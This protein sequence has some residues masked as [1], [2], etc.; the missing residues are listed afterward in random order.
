MKHEIAARYRT[1]LATAWVAKRVL[2]TDYDE[3]D[4]DEAYRAV[5][6]YETRATKSNLEKMI[7]ATRKV[8]A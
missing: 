6:R 4:F 3:H 7:A 2:G 1:D 5:K 8:A